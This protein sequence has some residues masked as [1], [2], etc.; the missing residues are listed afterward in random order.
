MFGIKIIIGYG[1]KKNSGVEL[2][3]NLGIDGVWKKIIGK[4]LLQTSG[5]QN[6]YRNEA[7]KKCS[8]KYPN[9]PRSQSARRPLEQRNKSKS[10]NFVPQFEIWFGSTGEMH[11]RMKSL[12][13]YVY[14]GYWNKNLNIKI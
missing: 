14:R 7:R 4:V 11:N 5:S 9:A 3:W 1:E 2:Y 13:W 10:K 12:K 6:P 8:A